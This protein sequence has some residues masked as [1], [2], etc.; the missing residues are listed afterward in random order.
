LIIDQHKLTLCIVLFP[1]QTDVW[2]QVDN[3]RGSKLRKLQD[4]LQ[5]KLGFAFPLVKGRGIWNYSFGLLPHRRPITTFVG[6][7]VKLPRVSKSAITDDLI[8]ECH[9]QYKLALE[10]LFNRYKGTYAVQRKLVF[11]PEPEGSR[12]PGR[13]LSLIANAQAKKRE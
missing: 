2:D 12:G 4:V 11:V 9:E 8:A 3:P 5:K 1:F 7:P 10:A 13:R 6:P